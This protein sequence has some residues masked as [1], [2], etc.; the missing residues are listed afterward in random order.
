V[1]ATASHQTLIRGEPGRQNPLQE[2][3]DAEHLETADF[4]F[5]MQ[6]SRWE[7]GGL[8]LLILSDDLKVFSMEAPLVSL[9]LSKFSDNEP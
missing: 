7:T 4:C 8:S 5:K 3:L 9:P 1:T 2:P 6:L